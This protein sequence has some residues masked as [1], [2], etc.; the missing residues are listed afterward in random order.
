MKTLNDSCKL[1]VVQAAPVM[2]DRR[3]CLEKA[4]GNE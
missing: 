4:L 3:R 2:F 1:A